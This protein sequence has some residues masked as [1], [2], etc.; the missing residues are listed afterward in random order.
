MFTS[1][2]SA[3]IARL[4]SDRVLRCDVLLSTVSGALP[5]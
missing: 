1:R 5:V 2:T 4:E 3:F